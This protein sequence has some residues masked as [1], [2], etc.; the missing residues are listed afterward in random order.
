MNEGQY[1]LGQS[2]RSSKAVHKGKLIKWCKITFCILIC[3]GLTV[4][5]E[6]STFLSTSRRESY[7]KRASL[8]LY[9]P[10][11]KNSSR[12]PSKFGC[13]NCEHSAS[14]V[15]LTWR[16]DGVSATADMAFL[17]LMHDPD[18]VSVTGLDFIHWFV[19][20][21]TVTDNTMKL[22]ENASGNQNLMPKGSVEMRNSINKTGYHPPCPPNKDHVYIFLVC[23]VN[24]VSNRSDWTNIYDARDI[25]RM[26]EGS[27]CGSLEGVYPQE[28]ERCKVVSE[29]KNENTFQSKN[30]LFH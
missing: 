10:C 21:M 9:S 27:L 28:T 5:R 26:L 3:V 20:N 15:P 6:S 19:V 14:S 7:G 12:I 22:P 8:T 11:F 4:F 1:L 24:I 30:R 13:A 16:L 29:W 25:V 2:G 18:A 17:L 23:L